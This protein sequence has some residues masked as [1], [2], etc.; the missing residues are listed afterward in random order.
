MNERYY[1]PI[2]LT[3][4]PGDEGMTVRTVLEKRLGVSRKLLSRLKLTEEGLTLNGERVYTTVKVKAGDL[5]AIRMERERSDDILP[6]EMPLDIVYEDPYLLILNKTAGVI[7]HPTH[8][9]YTHTLANGVV[10]LWQTRG[11]SFR[12]RPVHRL[13][14]ETSGVVAVA[15]NGYVHQQLSEQMQRGEID[16]TYIAFVFGKP[17]PAAGTVNEPIDRNPDA[18]HIRIVTPDGYPS[19]THYETVQVYGDGTASL[20]RLKLETGRTHQIRVHMRHIGCPLIGDKMYGIAAEPSD[21]Q[22]A[23]GRAADTHGGEARACPEWR[24]AAHEAAG[25]QALHAS[26]LAFTHPMTGERVTFRASLPEDLRQLEEL[27]AV[28]GESRESVQ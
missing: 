26:E 2:T 14:Q 8:G 9:H 6:Q 3:I 7:V 23:A 1:E 24:A 20:V 10:H 27:L 22:P 16:K 21:S 15:K 19:V 11:E 18:P 12:F 25:R 4:D 13:D 17:E 28:R 5:V